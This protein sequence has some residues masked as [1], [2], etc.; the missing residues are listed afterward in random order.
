[1]T[2]CLLAL[3]LRLYR[4]PDPALRWDEGWTLAHGHLPWDELIRIAALEWHPPLFYL[5]FKIWRSIAGQT[6]YAL[7]FLAVWAGV[8]TV[9][10]A[11]AAARAWA[12]SRRAALLAAFYAAAAPLLVYYGQVNR[13]YAWTPAGTLLAAWALFRATSASRHRWRW[14]VASGFATALALYLLYYTVWP[15]AAVYAYALAARRDRR[16]STVASALVAAALFAP[17]LAYAAGAVQGRF[18]PADSLARSMGRAWELIGPSIQGLVFSFG[19]GP[20]PVWLTAGL[21][22]LG[23]LLTPP[24]R[25]TPML[26]PALAIGITVAGVAYGAQ[27]VRFFAVR[28]FVPAAPFLGFGLAWALDRLFAR[29]KPLLPVAIVALA[30]AF[31]PT[32]SRFVY[33]KTLEV[34]DPFDP[35]A[36]WNYLAPHLLPGDRVFFN[37]LAKAGWYEQARA[38]RGAPWSY[39]LRWDPIVEPMEAV[40]IPR[41]EAAMAGHTRL[42]FVLYKG[43]TGPNQDLRAW[44]AANDRLFPAW[45]GWTSDTLFLGYVAPHQPPV[46]A[47]VAAAW[48]HP[49]LRLAEARFTQK[50]RPGGGIAIELTWQVE[51]QIGVDAKVFVHAVDT[52]GRLVA[53]HDARPAGEG[54]PTQ[55][56][57]PGETIPDRHG[58]ALPPDPQ[59]PLTIRAGLYHAVTGERFPLADG[60]DAVVLGT[61]AVGP[62]DAP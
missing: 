33:A 56:L 40:V 51:G 50:A 3:A 34:V 5:L 44:L 23:L 8:L 47:P 46:D 4:L 62:L 19:S 9:P 17:W 45:E 55:A 59:G 52:D 61:V 2:A 42:W 43:A 22:L 27:A 41:I 60:A 6:N 54:R 58:I 21:L 35:Q 13:M 28:H 1:M 36:D 7:R 16:R 31:W 15:L 24:R 38:G 57:T 26:L 48:H 30:V 14:A 20:A 11:Y 18:Y 12:K 32:S 25:W 53:Q 37:N 49:P 39:A 10:L 29:W